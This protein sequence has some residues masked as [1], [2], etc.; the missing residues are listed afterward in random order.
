MGAGG[1]QTS[2]LFGEDDQSNA[3]HTTHLEKVD[4]PGRVCRPTQT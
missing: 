1:R 3:C 2:P 4:T